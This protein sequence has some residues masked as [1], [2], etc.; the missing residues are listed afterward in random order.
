MAAFPGPNGPGSGPTTD[1]YQSG[2][3]TSDQF[4]RKWSLTLIGANGQVWTLSDSTASGAVSGGTAGP[5]D[6]PLRV[7]FMVRC[8]RLS[9]RQYLDCK[10]YNL[11]RQHPAQGLGKLYNRVILRAGYVNGKFATIFDGTIINVRQGREPTLVE[12]YFQIQAQGGDFAAN[13]ATVSAS[14]KAGSTAA[15]I[16]TALIT[17]MNAFGSSMG[18]IL[19]L[20]NTSLIR[21]RAHYGQTIDQLLKYGMTFIQNDVVS[22]IAPD[23]TAPASGSSIEVNAFTGLIGMAEITG[24]NGV[25]FDVNLNPTI[26]LG[27]VVKLNN[28]D[29]N[30][31]AAGNN[32]GGGTDGTGFQ[33]FQGPGYGPPGYFVDPSADGTYLTVLFEH[34]GDSRGNDWRSHV[35]A[36]PHG[37]RSTQTT[38]PDILPSVGDGPTA[39][40]VGANVAPP[41]LPKD[42]SGYYLPSDTPY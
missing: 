23:Q 22:V 30:I 36:W 38:D 31:I 7:T 19:A 4:I 35:T 34:Y 20:S 26:Q 13:L 10:I 1:L 33:S 39:G 16:A 37:A 29:V 27:T 17:T 11:S 14:F 21:G 8:A 6:D 9:S 12:T 5:I 18:K 25:E 32:P 28:S 41:T 42:D 2:P 24:P 15:Q 40:Q 3:S